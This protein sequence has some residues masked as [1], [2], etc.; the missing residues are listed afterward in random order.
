MSFQP[1]NAFEETFRQFLQEPETQD[2][3]R[4]DQEKEI[5]VMKK[6]D[7]FEALHELTGQREQL[8]VALRERVAKNTLEDAMGARAEALDANAWLTDD[9][10][11]YSFPSLRNDCRIPFLRLEMTWGSR[12]LQCLRGRSLSPYPY[13]YP[14][15]YAYPYPYPSLPCPCPFL[16]TTN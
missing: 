2:A 10:A 8:A 7:E 11:G 14:Y 13:P 6:M 5:K 3:I 4:G 9:R 12:P 15:P 16:T 1:N